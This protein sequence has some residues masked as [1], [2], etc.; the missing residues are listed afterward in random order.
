MPCEAMAYASSFWRPESDISPQRRVPGSPGMSS[1]RCR[2]WQ[3]PPRPPRMR[4]V[5][6]PP[7]VAPSQ[8]Q[9]SRTLWKSAKR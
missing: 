9:R 3:P 5:V 1:S 2:C 4:V 8:E 6:F 7:I